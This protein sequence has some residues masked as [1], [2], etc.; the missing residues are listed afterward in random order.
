MPCDEDKKVD[1][2]EKVQ[3]FG[4]GGNSKIFQLFN[5]CRFVRLLLSNERYDL[6][7]VQDQ[8]YLALLGWLLAK[9]FKIGLEI[10]IHGLEKY[11]SWR[12]MIAKFVLPR[13]DAVR[14]VSGRLRDRLVN[15][16][17]VNQERITVVPIYVEKYNILPKQDY[18]LKEKIVLLTVCRL[19][20]V[21]NIVMQLQ[22]VAD[23][24]KDNLLIELWIVGDGPDKESLQSI[25]RNLKIENQVKF[26]GWQKNL[27]KFYN[28]ADIFLLTSSAEGWGMVVVE[29][30]QYG[31]PIIMT[32]V[33]LAGE[34]VIDGLSGLVVP[35]GDSDTLSAAIKKLIKDEKL[36]ERLGTAAKQ[37]ASELLSWEKT[38]ELYQAGWQKAIDNSREYYSFTKKNI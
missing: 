7:T 27:E 30:A 1:L 13:A 21:K 37:K 12:K 24:L 6:I 8:Y 17:H 11:N 38:L 36:R 34:L 3:A 2:S 4:V 33:G 20:P 19:V 25:V 18:R 5:V 26:W 29:A 16:L 28:Q 35:I 22:A 31:L 15:D 32:D 10:Q 14:A 23:L 9:K